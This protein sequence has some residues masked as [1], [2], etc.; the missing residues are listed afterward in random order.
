MSWSYQQKANEEIE[1][2]QE[3]FPGK[4]N[5]VR[6]AKVWIGDQEYIWPIS[7]LCPPECKDL[8]RVDKPEYFKEEENDC[9]KM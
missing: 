5:H 6:V 2:R 3:V 8:E 7:K 4:G 1:Y 9:K